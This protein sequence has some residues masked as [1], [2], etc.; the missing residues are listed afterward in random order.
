MA[1]SRSSSAPNPAGRV[2]I[3]GVGLL[4]TAI[5]ERLLGRR[6]QVVGI[7]PDEQA[8]QR[9]V[10]LGGQ[11]TPDF[12]SLVD[13]DRVILSLPN[14]DIVRDVCEQLLSLLPAGAIVLD[15]TTGDPVVTERMSE[16]A[17]EAK[18]SWL[19]A[20]VVGSSQQVRDGRALVLLGGNESSVSACQDLLDAFAEQR[21]YCGEAGSAQRMKLTTNLVLGLNRA[22]L[23]EG[24]FFAES[25]G[26]NL[27][28]VLQ[29]LQS[30]AAYSKA[31]DVKG[32]KMIEQDYEPQARLSQHLKDV[33]LILST[34]N[35]LGAALPLS[36]TH[37]QLLESAEAIHLGDADNSAIVETYRKGKP[38]RDVNG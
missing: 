14:S 22:A 21:I 17:N 35:N 26:L 7:D 32:A 33:R 38:P 15:T 19:E 31:M 27:P 28:K 18:L 6:Y 16:A 4:G 1:E 37:R 12:D 29:V 10:S 13:V 8:R 34:A 25:M 5:A 20:N 23:A 3:V 11:A 30:G 9:L 24:L 36:D 2:A